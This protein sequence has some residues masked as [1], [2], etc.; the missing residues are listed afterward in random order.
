VKEKSGVAVALPWV[1]GKPSNA[2][3]RS[4]GLVCFLYTCTSTSILLLGVRSSCSS[5]S[6][7]SKSVTSKLFSLKVYALRRCV[8]FCSVSSLKSIYSVLSCHY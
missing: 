8:K 4:A 3:G 6:A 2:S 5:S 1:L 7:R